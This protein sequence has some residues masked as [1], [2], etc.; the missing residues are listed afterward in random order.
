M[1]YLINDAGKTM[2][3]LEKNKTESL[4]STQYTRIN[5]K[6]MKGLMEKNKT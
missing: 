4:P 5:T 3:S 6:I 1:G 2:E